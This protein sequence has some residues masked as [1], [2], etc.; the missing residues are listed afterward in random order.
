MSH[1]LSEGQSAQKSPCFKT[2]RYAGVRQALQGCNG[3][4]IGST[5]L[6]SAPSPR[7]GASTTFQSPTSEAPG[8]EQC[9]PCTNAISAG[10]NYAAALALLPLPG[11]APHID[12]STLPLLTPC[13]GRNLLSGCMWVTIQ[14]PQKPE[15]LSGSW[16]LQSKFKKAISDA[17]S[18]GTSC[19]CTESFHKK[20]IIAP[21]SEQ[22]VGETGSKVI[23][24]L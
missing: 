5:S 13:Q 1:T 12:T 24:P 16:F 22:I 15:T 9:I 10:S 3:D 7:L 18:K 21:V 17:V 8:P 4:V 6:P 2:F 19:K 20:V 14:P 11:T 23:D